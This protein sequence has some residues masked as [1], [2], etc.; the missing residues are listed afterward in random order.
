MLHFFIHSFIQCVCFEY[1][2]YAKTSLVAQMVKNL[3][4]MKETC[5]Q[6]LGQED[7]LEKG[8]ATPSNT[9]S[10]RVPW[11]EEPG[12]IVKSQRKLSE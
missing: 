11:A 7:P 6:S 5:I 1:L 3:H 9:L 12:R 8:M 4:T 2:L 10:W